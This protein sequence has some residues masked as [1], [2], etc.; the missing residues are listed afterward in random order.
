[1]KA[2][3]QSR[4]ATGTPLTLTELPTPQPRAD[5]VRVRVHAASVNPV[6]WKMRQSGPLRLAARLVGP[7]PPVVPGVDFSGTVEA[8][9]A[10]VQG[11]QVG[12][13]V[14]GGVNFSRGQRGSY[15]EYVGVR[16]DQVCV[17]PAGFD[18]D[19][20]AGIG[21]TGATA[22]MAVVE[23]G[24][25]S[26]GKRV[27][28]LGASGGVGQLCVQVAARVRGAFVAGVCSAKNA[29]LVA[30]LGATVVI[31][32]A[33]GDALEQL[34]AHG[35]FDLI[36]DCAGGYSGPG[37]RALLAKGGIHVM[38]AGDS[39][40]SMAQVVVPPFSSRA[41]LGVITG[42]RMRPLVDAIAAGLV[43]VAIAQRFALQ[44][45]E[46]ALELSQG[47]RMIGKILLLP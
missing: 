16:A 7:R 12:D 25:I 1:M 38:V 23:M 18:L 43:T 10:R 42:A 40:L 20:A 17:L 28:V 31:D 29:A 13:A 24:R 11:V 21:V 4:W 41:I 19:V 32:Y 47:A 15:A 6:D 9:G 27:A 8:V 26:A 39:P 2:M 45:A 5:E 22:W 3:A 33:K 46:A 30:G 34:R 44:E 14:V 35:P 37:C 36:V